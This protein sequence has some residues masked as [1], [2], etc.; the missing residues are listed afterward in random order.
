M[1][2]RYTGGVARGGWRT[3]WTMRAPSASEM[4]RFAPGTKIMPGEREIWGRCRYEDH[5][6]REGDMG[7]MYVRRSCRVRVRVRVRVRPDPRVR[8]RVRVRDRVRVR[9][10]VGVEGHAKQVGARLGGG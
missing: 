2:G 7:E 5:A 4:V 8:V 1:Q 6:W 3:S 10:R 9:A